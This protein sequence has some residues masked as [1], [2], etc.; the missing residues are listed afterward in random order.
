MADTMSGAALDQWLLEPD[1]PQ[2]GSD[3]VVLVEEKPDGFGGTVK[4]CRFNKC[5]HMLVE[6]D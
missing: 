2:C 5:G 4:V 6:K 1:C 3:D